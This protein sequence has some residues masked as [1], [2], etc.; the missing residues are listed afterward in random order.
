[1]SQTE[2]SNTYNLNQPPSPSPLPEPP[3]F[4]TSYLSILQIR[5]ISPPLTISPPLSLQ[6]QQ[7]L[8]LFLASGI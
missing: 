2:T 8:R 1:M 5:G 7:D 4:R 6:L 3:P